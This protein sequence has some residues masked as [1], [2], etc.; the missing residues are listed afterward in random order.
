MSVVTAVYSCTIEKVYAGEYWVNRYYTGGI[1]LSAA[2]AIGEDIAALEQSVYPGAVVI[3]KL[4]VATTEQGDYIYE[5][6]VL[7]LAGA[8]DIV[9]NQLLPL[10]CVVRCDFSVQ[11]SRPSRKYLRGILTEADINGL[12]IAAPIITMINDNYALP[13]AALEGFVDPQG[14]D[15]YAGSC[16]PNVAMRQLRRGSKKKTTP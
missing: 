7:N 2:I 14:A 9:L 8:R 11:A 12:A 4:S 6:R 1:G 16:N 5:T 15:I 10:F 3:T 13:L